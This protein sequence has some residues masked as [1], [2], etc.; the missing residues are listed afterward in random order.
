MAAGLPVV[1]ADLPNIRA[2]VASARCGMLAVPGDAMSFADAICR[3]VDDRPAAK[4]MGLRGLVAFRAKYNWNNEVRKLSDLYGN[5][6]K[7]RETSQQP[8][9]SFP[10]SGP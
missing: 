4:A 8:Q 6:T 3:I 5:I 1:G 10:Q 2:I 9:G 7:E